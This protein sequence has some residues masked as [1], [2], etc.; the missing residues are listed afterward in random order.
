[1]HIT[2]EDSFTSART[3]PT[4]ASI[5][6]DVGILAGGT[7]ITVSGQNFP[8]HNVMMSYGQYNSTSLE[9]CSDTT[10]FVMTPPGNS[11]DVGVQLPVSLIF[12]D[13]AS[14]PT[15]FTFTYQPDPRVNSIHPLKTLAAGGT[16]LTVDGEGFDSVN[17]PQLIVHVL[18]TVKDSGLQ[19][20]TMFMS[21]CTVNASDT[22]KCPTPKLEI[23]E[24][25]KIAFNDQNELDNLESTSG[26]QTSDANYLL[27]IEGESLE[28]Y[29]G[30]KLDGD[31]S[32][33]DLSESLPEYSQIQVYILVPEFATFEGTKEVISKEHLQITGKRLSDGLDITDY[34]ITIG[35]G[36]CTMV[37][38]TSNELI[39]EIPAEKAQQ[40][41]VEHSVLV[42]PGTNLSPQ[43]IGT[44]HLLTMINF[45]VQE[46]HWCLMNRP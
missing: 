41:E 14:I 32:Y 16:T 20:K 6:P 42:H 26:N 30:I 28:F 33:S 37:G 18:H 1:M 35:I 40:E 39:C 4:I 7:R 13:Q 44:V 46:K 25:F 23:P 15:P 31:Q 9:T 29:L 45:L 8:Q 3:N 36:I 2:D 34:K 17:D 38:L 19:N 43:L 10:C 12:H 5:S 24:Q 27:D 21:S 22:L 11:S